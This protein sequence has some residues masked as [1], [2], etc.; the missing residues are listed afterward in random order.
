MLLIDTHIWL[1]W[2]LPD[3]PLPQNLVD[4]IETANALAVSAISCWEVVMLER[5]RRIELPLPVDQ[6]LKEALSGSYV[7]ALPVSPAVARLAGQL[8]YHHK[9]PADRFIITTA[10]VNKSKLISLDGWFSAY[11]E[12]DSLLIS[13]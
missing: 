7:Q 2:L 1:R 4:L 11:S 12:L 3:D 10:I 6:W 5:F 9:D 13:G 8:P